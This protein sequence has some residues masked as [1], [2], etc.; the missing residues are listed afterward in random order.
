MSKHCTAFKIQMNPLDLDLYIEVSG[1][2]D[3]LLT[4][5]MNLSQKLGQPT[6]NHQVA[7]ETIDLSNQSRAKAIQLLADGLDD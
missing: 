3:R 5:Y 4:D 1:H 6:Y 2:A 7:M